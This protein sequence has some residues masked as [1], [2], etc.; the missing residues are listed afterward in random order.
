MDFEDLRKRLTAALRNRVRNGE[1]SERRLAILTGISQP[2]VHN[3]LKGA[4]ILSSNASDQVLCSMGMSVLHLLHREDMPANFCSNCSRAARYV[5]VP[6]LEGW[7]G[8]CLPLPRQPSNLERYP[9]PRSHVARLVNPAVTRLAADE[10]MTGVFRE[11]D[12]ALLD[13]A[14][15]RRLQMVDG[16]LYVVMTCPR[17][18]YQ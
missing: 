7:L 13:R 3:V 6:V 5:E 2:H 1:L 9:F 14:T 17:C 11:N 8:P 15:S 4:R 10:Q 16:G 12:L 18:L